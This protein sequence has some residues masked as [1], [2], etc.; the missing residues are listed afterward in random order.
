MASPFPGM[1]PFLEE[2]SEWSSV[3]TRLINGISDA[4]ASALAPNFHVNI[5]QRVYITSPDDLDRQS[6]APDIYVVRGPHETRAVGTA[7]VITAPTF[8]EPEYESEIRD[9]Y[10]EIRDTRSREVVTTIELL[11]PFNKVAD[12]QGR[13]AFLRKRKTVMSSNVNWIEIDLL[14]AGK[15][16]SEVEKKSD[17][18]ALLKR[19]SVL[20]PFEV[21]YF[22]LR[23]RMPTI[24]VPLRPPIEDI[25][26]DLQ[27]V[28]DGVYARAYYADSIDYTVDIPSPRLR[29]AAKVWV[30]EQIN[31]WFE[32]RR[33]T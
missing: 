19:G 23:D 27:T 14:R 31:Q 5:E 22:D 7:G 20:G 1:D 21:W 18:Y 3:H 28:F 8:V 17:Y 33:Q 6:I 29:A 15:R 32:E 24:S 12:R 11:S 16:P 30:T 25:P 13:E 4:L 2:P 9:R 26:L 10:L